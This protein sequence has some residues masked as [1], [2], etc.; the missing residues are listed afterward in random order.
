MR[1]IELN[2]AWRAICYKTDGSIDFSFDATVPG[3]AH[4]DLAGQTLPA[5]IYARESEQAYSFIEQR[6]FSYTKQFNVERVP[7]GA[8]LVFRGLDTYARITLNGVVL[9]EC[10]NMFI[11]HAFDVAH[12]L[13]CGE[14]TLCVQFFSPIGR[15][16]GLPLYE[17]A[18]TRERMRIRRLQCTF[19]WDWVA[20]FVTC[21]IF[22]DVYIETSGEFAVKD[23]YVYTTAIG[24]GCASVTVEAEFENFAQ[25]EHVSME[26]FAPDG[27]RVFAHRFFQKEAFFKKHVD[28]PDAALWYP[29]GY[30]DQPLYRLVIGG[31]EQYFGIRT[32]RILELPDQKGSP[33]F[34]KCLSLKDTASAKKYDANEEFSGFSLLVNDLPVFCKGANWV[35]CEPFPSAQAREKVTELLT[36]AREANLNML[37]VWGGG[38][39]ESEHFYSECDRLGILVTQDF[40]MACGQYPEREED[41]LLQIRREAEYAAR[42]L[43]NHPSLV[44]WAGDNENAIKGFDDAEDFRGRTVIKQAI[45]PV[46]YRLDPHRRFLPSSPYGGKPYASK[47][48]GTTHNTQFLGCS[49][50][51]YIQNSDM[52]DYKEHF[53]EYLARFIAEEPSLGAV[54]APTLLRHMEKSEILE[55]TDA[56]E[57]YTKG[58]PGLPRSLFSV[59]CD[60]SA[61]ILGDFA[62]GEDRY[63]K[64]KYA[65][66]EWIR[67]SMELARRNAGFCN[68]ILYWMWN[69]CWP[70]ASGWAMVDYYG[71]PKASYYAFKRCAGGVIGSIEKNTD[72]TLLL[73]ND[74]QAS[75]TLDVKVYVLENGTLRLLQTLQT[76]ASAGGVT[77]AVSVP[78][79]AL[80]AGATLVCEIVGEGVL[81]RCFYREGNLKILPAKAPHIVERATDRVVLES[82]TYLHAVELEGDLIFS[83]NYF[84]MLPGERREIR[85]TPR[86]GAENTNFALRAYTLA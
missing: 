68:G 79:K 40:L 52:T 78:C 85:I 47:T 22:D 59:L 84:Q 51:P 69:D 76:V 19:G 5:D 11:P 80:P 64:L 4:T 66:Y 18:F 33:Y 43:R 21:G 45:E 57:F 14:N 20:R 65:Q 34:E 12:C 6:D 56:W 38:M 46:L 75:R 37:R 36:L 26:I 25:G 3:C 63:F 29:H 81:D 16:E 70:A 60:L 61:K 62:N 7:E 24:A 13:R 1:A 17:G 58:N 2:G 49:L 55:G 27:K 15:V 42:A 28:I 10:D 73:C 82:D 50:L 41:F 44:W 86:N 48:A 30:G 53:A 23:V 35:P 8:R 77:R 67:V 9:G 31:K 72:Y 71:L 32:V 83:D 39:F 74:T 54:C